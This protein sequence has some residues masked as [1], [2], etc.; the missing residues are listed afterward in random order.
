MAHH[1]QVL[2]ELVAVLRL[3]RALHV[4]H[5]LLHA[6]PQV[7][8]LI[9]GLA[10]DDLV[11]NVVVERLVDEDEAEHGPAEAP[12]V[13]ALL[14]QHD[15]KQR[16]QDVRELGGLQ[17]DVLRHLLRRQAGGAALRLGDRLEVKRRKVVH[18]GGALRR[19][20]DVQALQPLLQAADHGAKRRGVALSDDGRVV[21]AENLQEL[22]VRLANL[23]VR[24]HVRLR[25]GQRHFQ[26]HVQ[27]IRQR[28]VA[29]ELKDAKVDVVARQRVHQD[30]QAD[31]DALVLHAVGVAHLAQL[32][33]VCTEDHQDL[34]HFAEQ[35]DAVGGGGVKREALHLVHDKLANELQQRSRDLRVVRPGLQ[36]AQHDGK[37][38]GVK[39]VKQHA[40]GP[41]RVGGHGHAAQVAHEAHHAV[42][43]HGHAQ[44]LRCAGVSRHCGQHLVQWLHERFEL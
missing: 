32:Q 25:Y 15:L 7:G 3:Q 44:L 13:G 41:A 21:V 12:L 31:P 37:V 20:G 27:R 39:H 1:C 9:R 28:P 16:A 38:R 23:S 40:V 5:E 30:G 14:K 42:L 33:R 43:W 24:H 10:G 34:G 19:D 18:C 36:A 6:R 11:L 29:I 8:L 22:K 35:Q 2:R 26:G 17:A 4:G